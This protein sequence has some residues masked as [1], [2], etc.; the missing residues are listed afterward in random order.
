ML[1][2]CLLIYSCVCSVCW[3]FVLV[4]WFG[5]RPV[6]GGEGLTKKQLK[7]RRKRWRKWR[8]E[9]LVRVGEFLATLWP[10]LFVCLWVL[11]MVCLVRFSPH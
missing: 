9:V 1:W 7:K 11:L 3:A 5:P 2:V 10:F 4:M 8:R 6:F